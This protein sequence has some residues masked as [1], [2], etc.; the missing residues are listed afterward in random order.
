MGPLLTADSRANPITVVVR[1]LRE[2]DV[3]RIVRLKRG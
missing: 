3:S 2:R 1:G